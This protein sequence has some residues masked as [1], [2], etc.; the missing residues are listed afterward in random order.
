MNSPVSSSPAATPSL[1]DW[2]AIDT[3]LLDMDGTLLDLHYDNHI[4]NRV[5][6]QRV[7]ARELGIS[8][9]TAEQIDSV[10]RKLLERMAS[11]RGTLEFYNLRHWAEL[12]NLDLVAIHHEFADLIVYRPGAKAFLEATSN[13]PLTV[14]LATNAHRDGLGVKHTHCGLL[15]YFDAVVS[16][17]D[18]GAPKEDQVFWQHLE[19]AHPFTPARTL[20]IDD[21][22]EVLAS[23]ARYGIGHL[24]CIT[25]PDSERPPRTAMPYPMVNDLADLLPI[26]RAMTA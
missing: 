9:P 10:N 8:E 20:F 12:T 25:Q 22:P 16:S 13:S 5:L 7:A 6:P 21:N 24:L 19:A 4:W 15:G 11:V 3:V 1:L 23:A 2:D 26:S 18:Y 14:I 17:H